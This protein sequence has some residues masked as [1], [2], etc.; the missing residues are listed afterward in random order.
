[1]NILQRL[2]SANALG[3]SFA[4]QTDRP[5]EWLFAVASVLVLVAVGCGTRSEP[6]DQVVADAQPEAASDAQEPCRID[7]GALLGG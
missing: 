2:F 4:L 3:G 5:L 6:T 1:M 7:D